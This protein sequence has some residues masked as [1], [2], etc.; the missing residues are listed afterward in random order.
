MRSADELAVVRRSLDLEH[1]VVDVASGARERLLELRLVVDVA[2]ARVLDPLRERLDERRLHRLEP[3]FE[4]DR[5]DCGLEHG[6]ED[7]PAARDALELVRGGVARVLEQP[8][9][10]PE[11][12]RDGSAA[13][14]RDDVRPDLRESPLGRLAEAVEHRARDREL[15]DAVAEELEPL[16]RVGAV[17]DPRGVRED[18]L[19]PLGRKLRDQ[20]AELVRP[21]V[22]SRAQA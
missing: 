5:G 11:L 21:G 15:E 9:A 2:R 3:V 19:E 20:A 12:L 22:S 14:A 17:L 6:C 10:E 4:I 13:L 1:R 7:V 18:L 16:V 8:I